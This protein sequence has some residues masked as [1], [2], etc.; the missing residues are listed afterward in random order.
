M[1]VR[2]AEILASRA[3]G[4]LAESSSDAERHAIVRGAR[5]APGVAIYTDARQL[6]DL[7]TPSLVVHYLPPERRTAA[8]YLA[9]RLSVEGRC[10][11]APP[12]AQT[13]LEIVRLRSELTKRQRKLAGVEILLKHARN[14]PAFDGDFTK[15]AER[16]G[17]T[18]GRRWREN[19]TIRIA[20][21]RWKVL[22]AP[23]I[24]DD[25]CDRKPRSV[26]CPR[27]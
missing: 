23:A 9:H 6:P 19:P 1:L 5:W 20:V 14:D 4:F 26:G 12:E 11:D 10:R 17:W 7:K 3:C 24:D 15:I 13:D 27:G 18:S 16:L 22:A 8:H 2:G 25:S 21:E